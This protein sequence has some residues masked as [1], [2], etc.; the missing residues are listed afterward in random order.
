MGLENIAAMNKGRS[1][2]I[3][4]LLWTLENSGNFWGKE[5]TRIMLDCCHDTMTNFIYTGKE[6]DFVEHE[7]YDNDLAY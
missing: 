3:P 2:I 7:R 4:E 1:F 6:L 5:S